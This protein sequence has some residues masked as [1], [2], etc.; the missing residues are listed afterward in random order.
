MNWLLWAVPT[1]SAGGF[2]LWLGIVC[3]AQGVTSGPSNLSSS[4]Y[5]YVLAVC[6][7]VRAG[8]VYEL[9]M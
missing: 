4:N 5:A 6:V 1:A 8:Y 3:A 9:D 7:C 2:L